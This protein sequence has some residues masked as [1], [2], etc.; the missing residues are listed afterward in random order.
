MRE[1]GRRR[2]CAVGSLQNCSL[3]AGFLCC[4]PNLLIF[5]EKSEPEKRGA[6]S[7]VPWVLAAHHQRY[8]SG[9]TRSQSHKL[10]VAPWITPTDPLERP[11]STKGSPTGSNYLDNSPQS[12][13]LAGL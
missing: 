1:G 8:C 9:N 11:F 5:K 7:P 10:K 13:L 2:D 6:S 3:H 12:S 4:F